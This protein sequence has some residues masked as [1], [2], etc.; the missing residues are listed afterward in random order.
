MQILDNLLIVVLI[1]LAFIA[2]KKVSDK[3]NTE[4]VEY[5]MYLLRL[6]AAEKGVGFV[7]AP[8]IKKHTPIGQQFMDTLKTNGRATQKLSQQQ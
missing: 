5:L 2:G 6:N 4:T 1:V 8:Q 7:A 3:Y